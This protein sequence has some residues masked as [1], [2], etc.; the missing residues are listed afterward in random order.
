MSEPV[1]FDTDLETIY[2]GIRSE[3]ETLTGTLVRPGQVQWY[4]L[5]A[6]AAR[7]RLMKIACNEAY[8]QSFVSF[9]TGTMLDNLGALVGCTRLTAQA[10][11]T[12]I[13]F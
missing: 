1:I 12:L 8:K 13:R 3:F 11:R 6:F 4:L 10:S 7:E 2:D 9:A 5:R